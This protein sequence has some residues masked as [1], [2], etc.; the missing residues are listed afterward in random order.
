MK[1]V[2]PFLGALE[3]YDYTWYFECLYVLTL[4]RPEVKMVFDTE[5]NNYVGTNINKRYL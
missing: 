4:T 5:L 2:V 3:R 1:N